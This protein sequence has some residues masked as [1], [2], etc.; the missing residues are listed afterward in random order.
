MFWF[1]DVTLFNYNK[2]PTNQSCRNWIFRLEKSFG[3]DVVSMDIDQQ[4]R[5]RDLMVF[6]FK[7]KLFI[8]TAVCLRLCSGVVIF[9]SVWSR[10]CYLYSSSIF[11]SSLWISK[12]CIK[13]F[14]NIECWSTGALLCTCSDYFLWQPAKY[15]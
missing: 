4:V 13:L 2:L 12:E 1:V 11:V 10:I 3:F 7:C 8:C 9:K 14:L 6:S 5:W 15:Q